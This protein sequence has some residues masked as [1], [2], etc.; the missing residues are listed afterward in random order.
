VIGSGKST[1]ADAVAD[2][3]SCP[4]VDAD[5]TRKQLLGV[6]ETEPMPEEPWQGAY[7][8]SVTERVYAE[9][10]SRASMVVASGR[11]VVVDASFRSRAQRLAARELARDFGVPFRFVECTAPAD[12]CRERL[13][14]R[15]RRPT[16]SDGRPALL[17]DF[18]ARFEPVEELGPDEHVILD[19]T[20]PVQENLGELRSHI[21][22]WPRGL[23]A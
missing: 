21:V 17:D 9:V 23:V 2:E 12:V 6:R 1:I 11:P 8:P 15:S 5:R 16:P 14:L 3:L 4:I 19:T 18:A 20:R 7:D 22:T 10:M 13:A